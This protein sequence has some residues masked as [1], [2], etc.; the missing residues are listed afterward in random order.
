MYKNGILTPPSTPSPYP[1][2]PPQLR[3]PP[4]PES[5]IGIFLGKSLEL[6]GILGTGAY[7]VVYSALDHLTKTWYAVKALSK[8]NANGEPLDR[9]QREF[10]S[11]EIQL[12][13]QASAH[14]NI[15]SM[16]KIVDDPDC[17]YVVLEYCPEGDLFSNI[18]ERGRYIGDDS[19][20]RQAF[21]QI[22]DAVEHCHRLGIYHRDLKPENVLVSNLGSKVLLADFGLATTDS[23]SEDHGCGSTFY[24]SPEC[25]DQSSRK[26][27]YRC[28]PN[29]IWSLGVIL[30]NLT[31]G[32]N[33]WKQA[34]VEDS[35]YKAFT[36]N[37]NFLK[38]ILPLSD[39]LNEILGMIFECNPEDRITIGELKLRIHQCANFSAA[40]PHVLLTPPQSPIAEDINSY[41]SFSDAGSDLS[42]GSMTSAS[43]AS[44]SDSDSGYDSPDTEYSVEPE[45]AVQP[46]V[47]RQA[48]PAVNQAYALPSQQEFHGNPWGAPAKPS[49]WFQSWGQAYN[50]HPYEPVHAVPQHVVHPVVYPHAHPALYSSH[51][52]YERMVW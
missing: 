20:V 29:D 35:T 22:L 5:R 17:T 47:E 30:V 40:P 52:Q 12:H 36:R 7:G 13:Y 14:P 32:R 23:E 9:R 42:E 44:D 45:Q 6:R 31:C 50:E 1:Q 38:T 21:L 43:S 24:M 4:T 51:Y 26:P 19:L 41:D 2:P 34:S 33:P 48:Y 37:P 39:E 27:S 8:T 25:L 11:R 18:T 28:A 49:P 15:V 16:L 3:S 10:H 46:K